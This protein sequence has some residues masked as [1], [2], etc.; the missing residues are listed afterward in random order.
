MAAAAHVE[1]SSEIN[2]RSIKQKAY[3]H[4][5]GATKKNGICVNVKRRSKRA[6]APYRPQQNDATMA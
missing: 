1:I 5:A 4:R 2:G 6:S 3:Q